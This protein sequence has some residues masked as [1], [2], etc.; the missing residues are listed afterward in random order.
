L[1]TDEHWPNPI[2]QEEEEESAKELGE[3]P[4]MPSM[5][6]Q[7]IICGQYFES[8]RKLRDHKDNDHR[9]SSYAMVSSG[10]PERMAQDIL[11]SSDAILAVA[12]IDKS[13][14]IVAGKSRSSFTE[15]YEIGSI[16]GN[17]SYGGSLA[18]ATL[19]V[20]NEV[21]AAFG[22]PRA[23]ITLHQNCKLMLLPML[24][25]DILVGL[26]LERS[27]DADDPELANKIERLVA[28]VLK[29]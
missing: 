2:S 4:Q 10:E 15:R 22:E 16:G 12:I 14:K 27:A 1:E 11:S 20:V 18:I 17:T 23:I 24:S 3:E 26:V 25:Y 6:S 21:K 28:H 29:S 9:M 8:K 13:G 7:C 19:S 5:I